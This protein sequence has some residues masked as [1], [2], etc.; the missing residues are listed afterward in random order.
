[1]SI[2][3][4]S[5]IQHLPKRTRKEPLH[6][7]Q[8]HIPCSPSALKNNHTTRLQALLSPEN[9]TSQIVVNWTL[10]RDKLDVYLFMILF[11]RSHHSAVFTQ[12]PQN[13]SCVFVS[14][15]WWQ[16]LLI[17][18]HTS[19]VVVVEAYTIYSPRNSPREFSVWFLN[20]KTTFLRYQLGNLSLRFSS[21]FDFTP[22]R[23]RPP[24]YWRVFDLLV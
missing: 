19:I 20:E 5:G 13:P 16:A 4:L 18:F 2:T 12:K 11:T 14:Q 6:V 1:M 21:L 23:T 9:Q 15:S 17:R 8:C 24:R 22:L 7:A 3:F 10:S